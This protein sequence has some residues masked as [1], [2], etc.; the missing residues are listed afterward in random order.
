M[1]AGKIQ[2]IHENLKYP[3][4][5]FTTE[6]SMKTHGQILKNIF[7]EFMINSSIL[8]INQNGP[9]SWSRN[10]DVE[11]RLSLVESFPNDACASSV[12]KDQLLAGSLWRKTARA[13]KAPY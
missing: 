9:L 10:V 2:F 11:A 4:Y 12:I 5:K 1:A 7:R 6:K 8:V 13:S 3:T